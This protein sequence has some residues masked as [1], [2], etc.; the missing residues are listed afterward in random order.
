MLGGLR[1]RLGMGPSVVTGLNWGQNIIKL[2]LAVVVPFYAVWFGSQAAYYVFELEERMVT[3]MLG[4]GL[5]IW[6]AC[7]MIYVAH[8]KQQAAGYLSFPSSKWRFSETQVI[9]V[10]LVIKEGDI[11]KIGEI[12]ESNPGATWYVYRLT[13]PF[14]I[15]YEDPVR[16]LTFFKRAYWLLP[17]EWEDQFFFREGGEIFYGGIPI[18]HPRAED[19]S[20]HVYPYHRWEINE[21]ERIPVCKLQ[22]SKAHYQATVGALPETDSIM[23]GEQPGAEDIQRS[24]EA[25]LIKDNIGLR[26]ERETISDEFTA[27]LTESFSIQDTR[28]EMLEDFKRRYGNIMRA[29]KKMRWRILNTKNLFLLGLLVLAF[30]VVYFMYIVPNLG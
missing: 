14:H 8:I 18:S 13:F 6:G 22:D 27:H 28:K 30:L 21:R 15:G 4:V 24:K 23:R 10:D 29:K 19:V 20:L 12:S 16:G 5:A 25:S 11:E 26:L 3:E 7:L 9:C 1:E 17:H 2:I